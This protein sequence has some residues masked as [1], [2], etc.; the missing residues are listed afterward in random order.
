MWFEFGRALTNKCPKMFIAENVEGIL[1]HDNGNSFVTICEHL[2]ELG[3]VIDFEVINSKYFGVPQNRERVFIWGI[4]KSLLKKDGAIYVDSNRRIKETDDNKP[5]YQLSLFSECGGEFGQYEAFK[6]YFV[7]HRTSAQTLLCNSEEKNAIERKSSGALEYP[8]CVAMRGRNPDNPGDR[9]SGGN[10][11]QILE[12][13]IDKVVNTLSTVQK[14]NLILL[15]NIYD[16]DK[17]PQAGR[18]YS[19]NGLA[20]TLG[21][22]GGGGGAKTGLYYMGDEK[23]IPINLENR[24]R[25]LTPLECE[26]LMSWEDD[27]TKY[28]IDEQGNKVEMVDTRR[29]N[30]CGNGI[31]SNCV[32]DIVNCMIDYGFIKID[33]NNKKKKGGN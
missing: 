6:K 15:G 22:Q 23:V 4:H 11:I 18:V 30:A 31:V 27:W 1:S 28:G 8:V 25:K 32:T 16:E 12:P 2:C 17:N 19:I 20:A 29:Y 24:L 10:R 3:Y 14:D 5:K 21:S 26:R 7:T 9:K 13:N 33:N